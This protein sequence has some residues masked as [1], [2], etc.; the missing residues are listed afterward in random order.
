MRRIRL[1][2]I[3]AGTMAERRARAFM[4]TRRVTI[5][6]IASRRL[7]RAQRL[8]S[9]LGCEACFDDVESLRATHPDAVLIEVPHRVQDALTFWALDAGLN[10]L[11]GGCLAT[12]TEAGERI[13][14][15]A[16]RKALVVEAGYEARYKAVWEAARRLVLAGDLGVPVAIRSIALFSANPSSWYYNERESGGMPLTHMTYTFINPARWI[17]GEPE[18]VSAFA[19]R[20]VET[21]DDRVAEETCTANLLFRH[22]LI[23]NMTAGYVSAGGTWWSF[24]VV[25]S[26]GVLDVNPGD[27]DRGEYYLHR[28][29]RTEY[30]RFDDTPDPFVRQAHAFLDGACLNT[31]EHTLGDLR[32]AEAIV[33]SARELRTVGLTR[34]VTA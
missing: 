1:G 33:R 27:M 34:E 18:V 31:P 17:F 30:R 16:Q 14:E 28:G 25:G 5:C 23:G 7:D 4:D 32:V 15:L 13:R 3:G 26:E 12:S 24:M 10:V 2:V 6:G 9:I 20:L 11:I 29:K 21:S 19:N 22:A 8:G